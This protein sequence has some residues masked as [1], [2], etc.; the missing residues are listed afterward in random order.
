MGASYRD[1]QTPTSFSDV[2]PK[3]VQSLSRKT[4]IRLDDGE[5]DKGREL[6]TFYRTWGCCSDAIMAAAEEKY[7]IPLG[8]ANEA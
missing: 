3:L 6:Q 1:V 7:V 2:S 8:L 4:L 5:S